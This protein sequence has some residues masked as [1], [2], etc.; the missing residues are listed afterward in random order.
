MLFN[1]QN[2]SCLWVPATTCISQQTHLNRQPIVQGSDSSTQ[3]VALKNNDGRSLLCS[4]V[5]YFEVQLAKEK[6][7][8]ASW[9]TSRVAHDARAIGSWCT[10]QFPRSSHPKG[11]LKSS[12]SLR[13]LTS[14]QEVKG[15]SISVVIV[16]SWAPTQKKIS[17]PVVLQLAADSWGCKRADL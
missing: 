16:P 2:R 4:A 8:C 1:A 3:T 11:S 5:V 15:S 12:L 14:N 9:L 6:D 7:K 10:T 13:G 17:L